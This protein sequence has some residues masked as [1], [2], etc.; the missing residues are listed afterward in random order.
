MIRVHLKAPSR[1]HRDEVR[2]SSRIGSSLCGLKYSMLARFQARIK[3]RAFSQWGLPFWA[4][5]VR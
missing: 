4:A 1:T 5:T 2:A 3:R